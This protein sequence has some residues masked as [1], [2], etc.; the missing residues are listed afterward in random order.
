ML[1][2]VRHLAKSCVIEFSTCKAC[3]TSESFSRLGIEKREGMFLNKSLHLSCFAPEHIVFNLKQLTSLLLLH[4]PC[5]HLLYICTPG[6]LLNFSK[7][8]WYIMKAQVKMVHN[9]GPSEFNQ[10]NSLY[11]LI[12][13][14]VPSSVLFRLYL[15]IEKHLGNT[16][17]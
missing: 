10:S 12:I 11:L 8:S 4:T 7:W 3:V 14:H 5:N 1:K 15:I 9:E 6:L 2:H 13:Y 16:A 17:Y